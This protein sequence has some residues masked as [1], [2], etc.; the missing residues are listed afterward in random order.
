MLIFLDRSEEAAVC[1]ANTLHGGISYEVE[2]H[3]STSGRHAQMAAS[4]RSLKRCPSTARTSSRGTSNRFPASSRTSVS[5][6]RRREILRT[7]VSGLRNDERG[8]SFCALPRSSQRDCIH[9]SVDD[10]FCHTPRRSALRSPTPRL[11]RLAAASR[12]YEQAPPCRRTA[13]ARVQGAA[14]SCSLPRGR[15]ATM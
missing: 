12:V 1:F 4:T 13:R 6:A 9:P 10:F 2:R 5:G 15:S 3:P 7:I 11:P 8:G 14:A